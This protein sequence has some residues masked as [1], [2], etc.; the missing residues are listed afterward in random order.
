MALVKVEV[1]VEIP[2]RAQRGT[3][4]GAQCAVVYQALPWARSLLWHPLAYFLRER[5][6]DRAGG[7]PLY[8]LQTPRRLPLVERTID[9]GQRRSAG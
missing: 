6:G 7:R 5:R 3:G 2:E 1:A 8:Y 9:V 4:R